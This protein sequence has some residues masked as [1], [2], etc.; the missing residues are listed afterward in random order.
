[1]VKLSIVAIIL[2]RSSTS[3]LHLIAMV[4]SFVCVCC[5]AF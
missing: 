5:A 1:L 2:Q 4:N 3:G